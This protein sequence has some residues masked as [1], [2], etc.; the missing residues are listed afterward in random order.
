MWRLP[1]LCNEAYPAA[2]PLARGRVRLYL[3]SVVNC[4]QRQNAVVAG[5]AGRRNGIVTVNRIARVVIVGG[6]TAGWMAAAAMS[7]YFNDGRRTITLIESDAIGTVGVGEAT[8]PPIRNFNAM[9][10]LTCAYIW[11]V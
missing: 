4:P 2:R 6:G 9:L 10:N 8:I 3:I 1:L 7:R 5:P 11:L